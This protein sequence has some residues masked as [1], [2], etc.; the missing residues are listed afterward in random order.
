MLILF[1]L[2]VL[3]CSLPFAVSAQT[4]N[5]TA[6]PQPANP[7]ASGPF[8]RIDPATHMGTIRATAFDAA[9]ERLFTASDDKTVKVWQLPQGKLLST[10]RVPILEGSE[11]QLYAMSL[12]PDGRW[13]AM[14]GWTGWDWEQRASVYIFDTQT[15]Q[16]VQRLAVA[17]WTIT[18]LRFSPDGENIAVGMHG[19][20]GLVVVRR[21]TGQVIAS[22]KNY[23]NKVMDMDFD[24]FGRLYTVGLDGYIRLYKQDFSFLARRA[25]QAS[26]DAVAVRASPD[27][28][29]V[30]VG[31]AN[32]PVVEILSARDLSTVG[33]LKAASAK[34]KDFVTV[35]WSSDGQQIYAAGESVGTMADV[36]HWASGNLTPLPQIAGATAGRINELLPLS[37][38]RM[39]FATDSPSV[40]WVE[41]SG[42]VRLPIVSAQWDFAAPGL[43][44]LM[45]LN[46]DQVS[47][48]LQ[49]RALSFSVPTA[50]LEWRGAAGLQRP[51]TQAVG[52][53][54]RIGQGQRTLSINGQ[55]VE[56]EV[57]EKARSYALASSRSF[58]VVGTEWAL[59]SYNTKG[60]LQ[61]LTT[62]PSPA[63]AVNV[64]S[65]NR[66]V[67]AALGDG[68]L[69]W[70]SAETGKEL[71]SVFI[72]K[73]TTDWV[74]WVPGGHYASSP[75]GDRHIGWHINRGLDLAPDFVYA[76]QL[77]RVLYRPDMIRAALDTVDDKASK[78]MPSAAMTNEQMVQMAP[79]RIKLRLLSMNA[80]KSTARLVVEGERAGPNMQDVAVYVN[81]LPVTPAKERVL[82][83]SETKQFRREYEVVLTQQ[84]NDIRVEAFTGLSMGLAHLQAEL[85]ANVPVTRARGD[86]YVLAIGANQ[87]EKLS[88]KAWLSF[89]AEDADT[90]A[91]TLQTTADGAFNKRYIKVLSDNATDK[92]TH[93]NI[94]AALDFLKAAKA[95]DTVILFL[96]SH[97]I[98]DARGNYYF[99]PRD[100]AL[101]DLNRSQAADA[102]Q[103]LVSWQVF[104]DALR[105]V[106]GQ[107][108]LVVDTCQAERIAGRFDTNA[109]IKRS[110]S[111]QFALMLASGEDEAS[112]EYD[113][114][115]HGLFTYGLLSAW[116]EAR[117]QNSEHFSLRDWFTQTAQVVQKYRDRR[118]GP[119]TPLLMALPVLEQVQMQ[120]Q[121]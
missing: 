96:A 120:V 113:L 59:R 33:V 121:Q 108:I 76:V 100:V 93:A 63:W 62:T 41:A 74:A 26:K 71:L 87:F 99:V 61:W 16:M 20:G 12:S 28:E 45:S 67:A 10:L 43:N 80:A 88:K 68:T 19:Q 105:V 25:T 110:V 84:S 102:P 5:K 103:K 82:R 22:D 48:S 106:A 109:L 104:F 118:I 14:G 92:P 117:L 81:D 38:N 7:Q 49:G 31:F 35:A 119:Q 114:A 24:K 89:A 44:L 8:L 32:A 66:V 9:R 75:F 86:L 69:R 112:Q 72:H 40:G 56:L 3:L 78:D 53:N 11:G 98:S 57:Y 51:I 90:F 64:S 70:F 97:G 2:G 79:P 23:Q 65:D 95:Q 4:V 37:K 21:S 39:L 111:S 55:S 36:Y 54:V 27:G 6:L 83:A 1:V 60:Q 52:W 17:A 34:Q 115:G 47:I 29:R 42:Q 94:L 58:A 46:G 101:S 77:E 30:A 18:S 91:S 85:P 107:R 50:K 15:E 73:N 116:K 13:L